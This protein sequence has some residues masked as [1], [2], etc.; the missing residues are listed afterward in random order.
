ME[1]STESNK[2]RGRPRNSNF[3][4]F[5]EARAFVRGEMIPS[6]SKYEDWWNRNKPKTVPRFPYR[7]YKEWLSWNDFLGNDNE[8]GEKIGTAWRPF[9]EA[10]KWVHTLKLN[11]YEE[12]MEYCKEV[13]P[14]EDIPARPDLV[15][16]QWRSWKYWLGNSPTE[17]IEAAKQGQKVSVYYIIHDPT[18]PSNVFDFGIEPMGL[19]AVKDRC[20]RSDSHVVRL[21]WHDPQKG[22]FVKQLVDSWSL[23]Y[24]GDDKRRVAP[25]VFEII[26][27]LESILET[28]R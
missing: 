21:F 15:Y 3:L 5:E 6:R 27:R 10:V 28:V 14:P 18:V 16:D 1:H 4:S 20:A 19:T 26:T 8:F 13:K 24:L 2:K 25:N 9:D 23:P 11:T 12:W 7:V 22:Q 17:I